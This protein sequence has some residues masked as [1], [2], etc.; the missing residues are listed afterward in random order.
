MELRRAGDFKFINNKGCNM[1]ASGRM[2][3]QTDKEN[4]F[5]PTTLI[6]MANLSME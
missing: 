1:R 4:Y 2:I 5:I 3:N 6:I